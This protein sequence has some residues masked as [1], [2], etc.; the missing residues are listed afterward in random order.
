MQL[1]FTVNPGNTSTEC[2]LFRIKQKKAAAENSTNKLEL[3]AAQTL[4]HPSEKLNEFENV[5]HQLEYRQKLVEKFLQNNLP[6][7]A[8]LIFCAGRGGMLTPVPSG[9]IRVNEKL[10]NFSLDNPVYYHASNLGAPIA[11][12]IANQHEAEAIIVD[13]VAVDEFKDVARISGCEDFPRFSFVHALNVRSTLRQLS[14]ELNTNFSDLNCV[15]AHL[16]AGFSIAA[17]EKGEIVDND[18]RMETAAFTPE[19]AGGVPPIP[20]VEACFSGE[21]SKKEIM[22]RLYGGG[23]VYNYLGTKD[24]K[25]VIERVESGEEKANLIY[26]AM[27]YQLGKS[28]AAMA[29]VLNF[30]LDG[31]I[32]TGGLANSDRIVGDITDKVENLGE[33]YVFP[34]SREKEA[35]AE[36]AFS[37]HNGE[38]SCEEWPVTTNEKHKEL[39]REGGFVK[40]EIG[41]FNYD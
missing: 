28:I 13:P 38:A 24:M 12:E 14:E 3:L 2:G 40:R 29:S 16:G 32:L 36:T 21:F 31:I 7:R 19:R 20:L 34:G 35:L 10:V 41:E 9:A 11:Y 37:V 17:V 27:I 8:D 23:G 26:R 39:L 18:N 1:I 22:D 6:S 33:V 5:S 15:V 4:E 25:E 30:S